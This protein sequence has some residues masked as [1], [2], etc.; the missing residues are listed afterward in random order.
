MLSL[1][2]L[3]PSARRV[4]GLDSFRRAWAKFA[5]RLSRLRRAGV[6]FAEGRS[7]VT[8]GLKLS[9]LRDGAEFEEARSGL[10]R[11]LQ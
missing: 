7:R 11:G 3:E 9:L 6:K 8:G 1:K 5:E 2:R 10:R 4:G